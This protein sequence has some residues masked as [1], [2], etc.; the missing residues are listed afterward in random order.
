MQWPSNIE[1]FSWGG[2][3]PVSTQ[4][5]SK[6]NIVIRTWWSIK[7]N[8]STIQT[9][10]HRPQQTPLCRLPSRSVFLSFSN[11]NESFIQHSCCLKRG[12]WQ[13][14]LAVATV[15]IQKLEIRGRIDDIW[16]TS[17]IEMSKNAFIRLTSRRE[18]SR[19][20]IL[21]D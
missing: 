20:N 4:L 11:E 6:V 1:I 12:C 13:Q 17:R 9:K 2:G 10:P 5:F 3:H 19:G 21:D 15:L 18:T 8:Q 14:P 16:R 7:L